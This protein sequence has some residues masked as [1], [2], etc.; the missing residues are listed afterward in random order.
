LLLLIDE[1]LGGKADRKQIQKTK[2]VRA[3]TSLVEKISSHEDTLN[4][5]ERIQRDIAVASKVIG[6]E[7]RDFNYIAK[8]LLIYQKLLKSSQFTNV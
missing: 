4:N 5:N 1:N 7:R 8:A 6:E 2:Y 3:L